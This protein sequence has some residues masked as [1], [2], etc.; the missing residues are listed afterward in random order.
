MDETLFR[1]GEM[2]KLFHL[3]VSIIRHYEALGLL[4]PERV[5][6]ATGYR[7]YGPRQF[8]RFNTIRYLRALGMP[9]DD[10]AD[11]LR[12]R[13]VEKIEEKL[14]AQ[15][16]AVAEKQRELER[17][18][19][20]IDHR[21]DQLAQVQHARL[22]EEEELTLPGC[23]LLWIEDTL[24]IRGYHD[25]EIPT[26]RF[27]EAQAED[28]VFLGKVGLGLSASHLAQGRFSPYDGIFLALEEGDAFCG[29]PL[30]LPPAPGVRIRYR[31]S[32]IA[33]EQRYRTLLAHLRE[34]GWE[35]AGFS[36]EI[37]VIDFGITS[38]PEKFVT[39][40]S[41]PVRSSDGSAPQIRDGKTF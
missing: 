30:V 18:Q 19:R 20:K 24:T 35:P 32:H 3:S 28:V 26:L 31:G 11:F 25:M 15:K 10:I 13:D 39:E 17:I 5:D 7:Y 2:A 37:T 38:D 23:R 6:P 33:A 41:I 14:R 1:I 40:I 21:L 4:R 8:D 29:E 12:N 27:A 9:L 22:D 34:R 36:R 16:A